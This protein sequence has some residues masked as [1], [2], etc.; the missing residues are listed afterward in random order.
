MLNIPNTESSKLTNIY[1]MMEYLNNNFCSKCKN[2]SGKDKFCSKHVSKSCE[3]VEKTVKKQTPNS[4]DYVTKILKLLPSENK[5][6]TYDSLAYSII[7]QTYKPTEKQMK[8]INNYIKI[9]EGTY[10]N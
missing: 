10:G 1:E 7:S 9:K 4:D 5:R 3:Y 6:D 2:F 8:F